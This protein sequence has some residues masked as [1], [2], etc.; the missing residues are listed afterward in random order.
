[1]AANPSNPLIRKLD[2]LSARFDS[3]REQLNDPAVL[4]NHQKGVP[5]SRESGQLEPMV[6][7]YRDYQKLQREIQSLQEMSAAGGREVAEPGGEGVPGGDGAGGGLV[8]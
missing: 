4:A 7:R 6:N 8:G 1:M 2:E 5:L 3:L